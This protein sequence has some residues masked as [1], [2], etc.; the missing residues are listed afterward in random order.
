MEIIQS[1]AQA[2]V[3]LTPSWLQLNG[4]LELL[5]SLLGITLVMQSQSKIVVCQDVVGIEIQSLA[6]SDDGLIP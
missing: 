3:G 1:G 2:I 5:G 4:G 6:I